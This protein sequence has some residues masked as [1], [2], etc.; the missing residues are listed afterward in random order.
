MSSR[1]RLLALLMCV[2]LVFAVFTSSAYI[3]H[4]ANHHCSGPCCEICET[5]AQ[6]GTLLRSFAIIVAAL[7]S[8]LAMLAL[9]RAFHAAEGL[10]SDGA[11]TLVSWKVRL[12]N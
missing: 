6:L 11:P 1:K 12:N 8:L 3:A 4:M 10:R 2:S 7:I 9:P 5:I